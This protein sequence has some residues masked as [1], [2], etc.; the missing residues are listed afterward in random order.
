[1]RQIFSSFLNKLILLLWLSVNLIGNSPT[2]YPK[3]YKSLWPEFCYDHLLYE[4]ESCSEKILDGSIDY[5]FYNPLEQDYEYYA[6]FLPS[7]FY[8]MVDHDRLNAYGDMILLLP[9]GEKHCSFTFCKECKR[10]VKKSLGVFSSEDNGDDIKMQHACECAHVAV[11]LDSKKYQAYEDNDWKA[12]KHSTLPFAYFNHFTSTYCKFFYQHL[13]YLKENNTCTC[14]LPYTSQLACQISNAIYDE[15]HSLFETSCLSDLSYKKSESSYIDELEDGDKVKDE[16]LLRTLQ[17]YFIFSFFYS[18]YHAT[19]V[20]LCTYIDTNSLTSSSD[21]QR[22]YSLLSVIRPKFIN[23]YSN[24]LDNH[25]HPKIYYERGMCYF[26]EGNLYASLTDMKAVINS[27]DTEELETLLTSNFYLQEGSSYAELGQYDE[28]IEALTKSIAKDLNNKEAYFERAS[29]YFETGDFDLAIADYLESG[30]KPTLLDPNDLISIEFSKYLMSGILKGTGEAALDFVPSI[31]SSING[32]SHA[33][34]AF[35]SDPL[36]CSKEMVS[37]CKEM[38]ELLS[39][40]SC[41][42]LLEAFIPE[43]RD[44]NNSTSNEE[45]ARLLG[46]MIG[47]YGTEIFAPAGALKIYKNLRSANRLLTLQNL[48]KTSKEASII[49][50]TS[51]KWSKTHLE[52]MEKFRTTEDFL[53]TFKGYTLSENQIRKILHQ[54]GFQTFP[55]PKGIPNNFKVTFSN[56]G[57][58]MKYI[59][60]Q[61]PHES[62]RVMPGKPHSIKASQRKPYVIYQKHGKT[63]DKFGNIVDAASAEAHIPVDE[64]VYL[65]AFSELVGK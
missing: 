4:S 25:P 1:M 23:L 58:G 18:N 54:A 32:L 17:N 34:W 8:I 51:A 35:G 45:K 40:K 7:I 12:C 22:L 28:A 13:C 63:L 11:P 50:E 6:T 16:F 62:I 14:Y 3:L 30:M 5:H 2:E 64:F 56:K 21:L 10:P 57:C 24:C 60:P 36:N 65:E 37:T 9:S 39:Q 43:V 49:K 27:A 31:L 33:L 61:N 48:S 29:A 38:I 15:M 55:R 42:E 20:D 19:I 52:S 53:N 47:K 41:M 59:N 26:H 44:F 46:Y